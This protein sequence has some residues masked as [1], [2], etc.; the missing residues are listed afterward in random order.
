MS[1]RFVRGREEV[2]IAQAGPLRK[3]REGRREWSGS[4]MAGDDGGEKGN[5]KKN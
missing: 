4:A 2:L 3:Q 5:Q 1:S